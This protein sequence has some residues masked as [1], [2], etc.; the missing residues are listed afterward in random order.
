MLLP[1]LL[2]S[3]STK[4]DGRWPPGYLPAVDVNCC[5]DAGS[6]LTEP[7]AELLSGAPNLCSADRY[8]RHAAATAR[9]KA[10]PVASASKESGNRPITARGVRDCGTSG[11]IVPSTMCSIKTRSSLGPSRGAAPDFT[12]HRPSPIA[13]KAGALQAG[14]VIEVVVRRSRHPKPRSMG[15]MAGANGD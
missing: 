10:R 14:M 12:L 1:L 3:R 11:T 2:S 8:L 15:S 7:E 6:F 4:F 13:R 9:C 5:G